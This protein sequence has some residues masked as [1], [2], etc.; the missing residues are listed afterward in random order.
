MTYFRH[1]AWYKGYITSKKKKKTRGFY[2]TKQNQV[3]NEIRMIKQLNV[4]LHFH[5]S[6]PIKP[7]YSSHYYILPWLFPWVPNS[8]SYFILALFSEFFTD[9][10]CKVQI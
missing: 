7:S 10:I 2:F 8:L 6:S 3:K 9:E 4:K 1:L 5:P